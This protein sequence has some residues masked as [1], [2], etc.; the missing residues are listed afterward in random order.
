MACVKR[1]ATDAVQVADFIFPASF[2]AIIS[3]KSLSGRSSNS[4]KLPQ[5]GFIR[6]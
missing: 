6:V 3:H 2:S 4:F 5:F 1:F